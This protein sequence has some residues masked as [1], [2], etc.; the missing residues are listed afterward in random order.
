MRP[1]QKNA[2]SQYLPRILSHHWLRSPA[3]SAEGN[4]SSGNARPLVDCAGKSEGRE[5]DG[6]EKW[7]EREDLDGEQGDETEKDEK[8]NAGEESEE[9]KKSSEKGD[10]V[11]KNDAVQG[12]RVEKVGADEIASEKVAD[13]LDSYLVFSF[14]SC[15]GT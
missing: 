5:R 11:G 1:V 15:A 12:E 14:L 13:W 2:V 8:E 10:G 6:V 3:D 9:T 4:A 7:I